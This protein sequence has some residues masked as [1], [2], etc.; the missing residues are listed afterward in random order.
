MKFSRDSQTTRWY[1]INAHQQEHS[2]TKGGVERGQTGNAIWS[3]GGGGRVAVA[4]ADSIEQLNENL[5][6][7][8]L[9]LSLSVRNT[10]AD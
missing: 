1:T 9:F 3:P 7:T 4:K 10:A 2:R 5:M 6:S 8:A